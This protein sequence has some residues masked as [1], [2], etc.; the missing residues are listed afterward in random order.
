MNIDHT[1]FLENSGERGRLNTVAVRAHGL[2]GPRN[3]L[4]FVGVVLG[5][6]G[7]GS[8]QEQQN[9]FSGYPRTLVAP[10]VAPYQQLGVSYSL[11]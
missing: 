1:I 7:R 3:R 10:N 5:P 6:S 8:T 9:R 2:H 11:S 4:R